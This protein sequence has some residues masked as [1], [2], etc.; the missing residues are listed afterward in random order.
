MSEPLVICVLAHNL[1]F[2]FLARMQTANSDNLQLRPEYVPDVWARLLVNHLTNLASPPL[3]LKLERLILV[4]CLQV[5]PLCD[6]GG[7]CTRVLNLRYHVQVKE[8][9]KSLRHD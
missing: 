4:I 2:I 6:L 8:V 3:V 5:D 1:G 7:I 9:A